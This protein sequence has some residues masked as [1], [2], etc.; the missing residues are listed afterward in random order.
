METIAGGRATAVKY[1]HHI[2]PGFRP[3]RRYA[4]LTTHYRSGN[5]RDVL[6]LPADKYYSLAAENVFYQLVYGKPGEVRIDC[7]RQ[8]LSQR[9]DRLDW[10]STASSFY[11]LGRINELWLG[12]QG[13]LK[14]AVGRGKE[15]SQSAGSLPPSSCQ[16]LFSAFAIYG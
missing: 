1:P 3:S 10:S 9:R 13:M 5:L 16:R 4:S 14:M 12:E 2:E 8:L 11:E 15:I 6:S 7:E